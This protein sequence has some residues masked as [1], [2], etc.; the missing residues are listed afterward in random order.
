MRRQII[1]EQLEAALRN[2]LQA[3]ALRLMSLDGERPLADSWQAMGG[4]GRT[5]SAVITGLVPVIHVLPCSSGDKD[6]DGRVKPGH[7]E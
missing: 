2:S 3:P 6:V 1:A 4:S 7:D 5:L